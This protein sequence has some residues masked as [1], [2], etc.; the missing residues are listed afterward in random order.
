MVET[1]QQ[2]LGQILF[3]TKVADL[4]NQQSSFMG[5]NIYNRENTW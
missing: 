1:L 4:S 5:E 2:L 3:I